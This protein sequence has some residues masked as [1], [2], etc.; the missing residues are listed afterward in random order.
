MDYYATN[1]GNFLPTFRYNQPVS[2]SG[3]KKPKESLW[4]QYGVC[5]W[6]SIGAT[7]SFEFLSPENGNDRLFPNV[8]KKLP[9]LGA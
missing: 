7:G 4:L 6:K 9:I 2:S 3:F 8:A 1:S 5:T